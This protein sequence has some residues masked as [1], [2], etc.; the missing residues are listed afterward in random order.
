[1][2]WR[3]SAKRF[4]TES[5]RS[6]AGVVAGDSVSIMSESMS[7]P[8]LGFVLVCVCVLHCRV[9]T[10]SKMIIDDSITHKLKMNFYV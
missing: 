6:V 5:F 4:L 7:A 8:H 10:V 2:N 1:M 3:A 9:F